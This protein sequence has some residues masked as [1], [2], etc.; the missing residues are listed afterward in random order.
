VLETVDALALPAGAYTLEIRA[1][2]LG[3]GRGS[4]R[5]FGSLE[6]GAEA[7]VRVPLELVHD[8][9]WQE[10]SVALHSDTGI[11]RIAVEPL[12][13]SGT[14]QIEW[15]RLRDRA[16]ELVKDWRFEP[17][18]RPPLGPPQPVVGGWQAGRNGHAKSSLQDGHLHVITNGGDPM[19]MTAEPLAQP[20]GAYVLELRMRARASGGGLVFGRSEPSG[21]RVGSGTP[22]PVKHDGEWQEQRIELDFDHDLHELRIDPC[23]GNGELDIDWIRLRDRDGTLVREWLFEG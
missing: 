12:G 22:F 17:P 1:E 16:G 13:D 20:A 15:I 2:S 9:K 19:L 18:P 8:R 5:C 21:Y 11:E 14:V 3:Q 7:T 23:T 4:V 10:C 6:P